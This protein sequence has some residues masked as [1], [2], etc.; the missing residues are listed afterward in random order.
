MKSNKGFTLIE[1]LA[2]IV[3]L[4]IIALIAT[5]MILGVVEDARKSAAVSSANGY[6]DAI[7]KQIMIDAMGDEEN[8]VI[9]TTGKI[10]TST[11][12]G[13]KVKG[14]APGDGSWVAVCGDEVVAYSLKMGKYFI[15]NTTGGTSTV[16]DNIETAIDNE[17]EVPSSCSTTTTGGSTG[18]AETTN[19]G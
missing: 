16:K 18:T 19:N 14:D 12:T 2:V 4:A 15:T 6:I 9:S 17:Y 7:E 10:L 8:A 11:L 1:L 5:P 3:I 13:V